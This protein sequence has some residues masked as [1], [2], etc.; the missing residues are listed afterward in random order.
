[1][2]TFFQTLHPA[3]RDKEDFRLQ[4]TRE[5]DQLRVV[6]QPLLGDKADKIDEEN[7]DDAAQVRAALSLPLLMQDVPTALDQMFY[8]M[9][10][11]FGE[12]RA[13][14]LDSFTQLIDNLNEAGKNAK[15]I[16]STQKPIK[17][18]PKKPSGKPTA[19][20]V[21]SNDKD[22][23]ADSETSQTAPLATAVA[24]ANSGQQQLSVL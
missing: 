10:A 9:V 22:T 6:I 14:L 13:P 8:G 18:A 7:P 12:A 15:N 1:M 24:P 5:G 21:A 20:E 23:G 17:A 4:V 19:P 16:I 2:N 11:R 3:L